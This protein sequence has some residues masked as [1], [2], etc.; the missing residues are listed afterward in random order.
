MI[1]IGH[2]PQLTP[3]Q[4]AQSLVP[5]GEDLK[6]VPV[7]PSHDVANARDVVGWNVLVKEVA[8]RVDEDLPRASPVQRLLELFGNESEVEA[9][10][11]RV[12]RHTAET[13]R[14][15]LRVA[16]L[17]ARAHLRAAPDGIPRRV[18]P[19][20]RRAVAHGGLVYVH[21]VTGRV[22]PRIKTSADFQ[23]T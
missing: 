14:E 11:E 3:Q 21:S 10:L 2:P 1:K 13:F 17:A 4:L 6:Y 18:R 22:T 23:S 20:N 9:L 15:Q 12:S 8:H 16:E 7:S 5:F 19:L